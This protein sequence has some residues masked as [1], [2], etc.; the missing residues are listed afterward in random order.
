MLVPVLR[1]SDTQDCKIHAPGIS[2]GE[3]MVGLGVPNGRSREDLA[4]CKEAPASGTIGTP[5]ACLGGDAAD[6]R[7][8]RRFHWLSLSVSSIRLALEP[9]RRLAVKQ[10]FAPGGAVARD[11]A[12]GL[13][14]WEG[15]L[16]SV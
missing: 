4:S 15:S 12:L 14:S 16:W 9:C 6:F 8:V 10:L 11:A 3:L 2:S 13:S 7:R 1:P 5:P